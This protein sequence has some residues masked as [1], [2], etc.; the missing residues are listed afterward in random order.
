MLDVQVCLGGT[1]TDAGPARIQC[2][3]DKTDVS[4]SH[5]DLDW[6]NEEEDQW[7]HFLVTLLSTFFDWGCFRYES[8]SEHGFEILRADI[9][10]EQVCFDVNVE[11]LLSGFDARTWHTFW[12]GSR[13]LPLKKA[14]VQWLYD[15]W[16]MNKPLSQSNLK[17]QLAFLG[18]YRRSGLAWSL[19][20]LRFS[21]QCCHNVC[22]LTAWTMQIRAM[23]APSTPVRS[24]MAIPP[25]TLSLV[26]FTYA[27]I[28]SNEGMKY[29]SV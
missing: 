10:G 11:D 4:Y 18:F 26:S 16:V 3:G 12:R 9:D 5:E 14:S 15:S 17:L 25:S 21:P 29:K 24:R 20:V 8:D 2:G 22:R 13:N 27:V 6:R 1:E 28:D 19:S 7:R 23:P